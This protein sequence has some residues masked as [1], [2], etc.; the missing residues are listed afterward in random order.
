MFGD[1]F[2]DVVLNAPHWHIAA[3]ALA[4]AKCSVQ[5]LH[6]HSVAKDNGDS[7]H[8]R[9]ANSGAEEGAEPWQTETCSLPRKRSP[10]RKVL[11]KGSNVRNVE[12]LLASTLQKGFNYT[13]I[14]QLMRASRKQSPTRGVLTQSAVQTTT[15]I[16]RANLAHIAVQG[17][18]RTSPS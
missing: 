12:D 4:Q 11:H 13:E 1:V 8:K 10:S 16:P 17:Q 15:Q 6:T 7:S 18:C 2:N 3:E 9:H 14:S 5:K